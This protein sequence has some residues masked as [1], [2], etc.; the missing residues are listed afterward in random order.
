MTSG[1]KRRPKINIFW[2][3]ANAD[4]KG[5]R[6]FCIPIQL[7]E[8]LPALSPDALRLYLVLVSVGHHKNAVVVDY[9][10]ALREISGVPQE[11]TAAAFEELRA[12]GLARY[13]S[14][15]YTVEL[16]SKGVPIPPLDGFNPKGGRLR[17]PPQSGI[18]ARPAER[19]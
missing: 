5:A 8:N 7:L 9:T 4:F 15:N 16:Q 14:S 12:A 6:F 19:Q 17:H 18:A 10:E 1:P 2:N 11:A 3:R 13:H